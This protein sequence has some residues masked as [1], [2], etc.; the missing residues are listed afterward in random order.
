MCNLKAKTIIG[1]AIQL[2]IMCK[3]GLTF[4]LIANHLK[5]KVYWYEVGEAH[6]YS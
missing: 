4:K 6:I 2:N 1:N 3:I 5:V